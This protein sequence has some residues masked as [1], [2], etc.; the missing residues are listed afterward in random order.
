MKLASILT[1]LLL[2]TTA[3]AQVSVS[4]TFQNA[5][6][7][8]EVEISGYNNSIEWDEVSVA[9]A[10]VE[11]GRFSAVFPWEKAGPAQLHIADQYSKL[12]LAPGDSLQINCD[13]ARFDST[14]HYTGRGAVANNYMAADVLEAFDR[15]AV[16]ATAQFDDASQFTHYVDSLEQMNRELLRTHESPQWTAVFRQY[17]T[18]S[19]MYRF[20]NHR[21]RYRIGY[22]R[23]KKNFFHK[24]MPEGYFAFFEKLDLDDEGA[25]DNG[26]YST[27]LLRYLAE[28][29]G[30][31]AV[32]LDTIPEERKMEVRTK[33]RYAYQRSLFK[34][35]VRD[36]QL[37]VFMKEQLERGNSDPALLAWLVSDYKATCT[38]PEYV[39]II[40]RIYARALTLMPGEPAPDFTVVDLDGKQVSL[41]SY[42]GMVVFL[43]FWA[44][45]CAPCRVAMPKVKALE[46]KF[47]DREDVAFLKVNV[48][49]ERQRWK[50]FVAKEAMGGRNFFA[51]KPETQAL[52]KAYNF[53]GVPHYVL[54]GQDGKLIDAQAGLQEGT[55]AKIR[56][57]LGL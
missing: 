3:S 20:V 7:G 56:A 11:R 54:I 31:N 1:V 34:G 43:D 9:K 28:A 27:A 2:H 12:F 55:E 18:S 15:K 22:D 52:L 10:K 51:G 8:S 37:S 42:K 41:S 38:N 26:M 45:W 50:D 14:L 19:T 33:Q 32:V 24:E 6:P 16:Q 44:T 13:Y 25:Y 47:K 48:L 35:K 40:D 4:G 46:E 23:E 49:D 17:I 29:P 36:H 30:Y 39:A 5:P 53:D 21:W 57:A